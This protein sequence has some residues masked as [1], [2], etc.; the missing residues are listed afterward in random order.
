[1]LSKLEKQKKDVGKMYEEKSGV[2]FQIREINEYGNIKRLKIL[3]R[4]PMDKGW[5]EDVKFIVFEGLENTSNPPNYELNHQENIGEYAY[6]GNEV[7]LLNNAVYGYCFSFKFEG[8]FMYVKNKNLTSK[9]E[10]IVSECWKMSLNTWNSEWTWLKERVIKNA[11]FINSDIFKTNIN[12]EKA[13]FYPRKNG[14]WY[15][16]CLNQ[17]MSMESFCSSIKTKSVSVIYL[18]LYQKDWIDVQNNKFTNTSLK[19]LCYVAHKSGMFVI[20]NIIPDENN[21]IDIRSYV[22]NFYALGVDRVDKESLLN[23]LM[24][25]RD[26]ILLQ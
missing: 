18:N 22:N 21:P 2:Y 12:S 10:I 24:N 1:M 15:V 7:E 9:D 4:I 17:I 13:I 11:L 23:E 26:E 8:N 3:I 14:I 19:T 25:S 16:R 6:F 20:L 5:I